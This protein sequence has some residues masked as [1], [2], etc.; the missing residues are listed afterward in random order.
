M[1]RECRKADFLPLLSGDLARWARFFLCVWLLLAGMAGSLAAAET[2]SKPA[3]RP[4]IS[5]FGNVEEFPPVE[6]R[7][8]RFLIFE[9]NRAAPGLDELEI[10]TAEP[11]PRNAAL[12]S[13]GA[14]ATASSSLEIPKMHHLGNVNDGRYGNESSWIAGDEE[15]TNNWWVQIELPRATRIGKIVWS[16]D[17]TGQNATRMPTRYRIE[18]AVAPDDW[19]VVA[20]SEE[21]AP[22]PEPDLFPVPPRDSS[23]SPREYSVQKGGEED[24]FPQSQV[25]A[26]TQTPDGYLWVGTPHSLVRFDGNQFTVF[27]GERSP[28]IGSFGVRWLY[29][30]RLG[31]LFILV[32]A[33]H[34]EAANNLIIY[35]NGRFTRQDSEGISL[36]GVFE[37]DAGQIWGTSSAGVFPWMNGRFDRSLGLKEFDNAGEVLFAVGEDSVVWLS[38]PGLAGKLTHGRFRALRGKDGQEL[39]LDGRYTAVVVPRSDGGAW[40]LEGGIYDESARGPNLWRR[41]S[42][43]GVL[44]ELKPFPWPVNYFAYDTA[45]GDSAGNLWIGSRQLGLVKLSPDGLRPEFYTDKEGLKKADVIAMFRDREG[46]IWAGGFRGGL[47]RLRKPLFQTI[48]ERS[49]LADDNV[50]SLSPSRQGGVW[51]GTHIAGAYR[52]QQDGLMQHTRSKPHSWS[53]M[54][55]SSGAFW[56]GSYGWGLTRFKDG[57]D[58][59]IHTQEGGDQRYPLALLEG[60]AGRIWIGGAHGL[61]SFDNNTGAVRFYAPPLFE[62]SFRN[63]VISLAEDN[64]GALWLGTRGGYLHRFQD[65]AFKTFWEP[66]P[67]FHPVCAIYSHGGGELWFARFGFGLTRLKEG[68]LTHYSVKEGLPTTTINGI[69]NDGR[70]FLWMTSK[71]GVW[72]ISTNDFGSFAAGQAGGFLWTRFT[73]QDGLPS[74]ECHGEQNKPSVCQTPDGRIWIPTVRG[75]GVIDP[76]ALTNPGTA[77]SA[78]VQQVQVISAGNHVL[79]LLNDGEFDPQKPH[80][81]TIPAGA[82]NLLIRYTAADLANPR[83]VR[84]RHRLTGLDP[85]WVD[86]GGSRSAI[87][88]ALAPGSFRFE[89][90]AINERGIL[91]SPAALELRVLP[92]WWQTWAFRGAVG[93]LLILAGPVFYF[94]R[95]KRLQRRNELQQNFSRQLIQRE[96]AERQRVAQQVHDVLGHELLLLKNI[97]AQGAQKTDPGSPARDQFE[98]MSSQASRALDETREISHRLRPVELDRLG[99]NHALEALLDSTSATTGLRVFKD[100]D[101]LGALLPVELQLH[102]YRLVQ[103]GLSN[104]LKHARASTVTLELKREGDQ[105]RLQLGDDGVGFDPALVAERRAGLGLTGLEERVKLMGGQFQISSSPGAGTRLQVTIPLPPPSQS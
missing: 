51:I 103:E 53:V 57:G 98:R 14:V 13:A 34:A 93:A 49:G 50:Y 43:D 25:N 84:F 78:I 41:L 20:T 75:V 22:N 83:K 17:R 19:K 89:L 65:G 104:V 40:I 99:L 27:G 67:E 37:D 46:N 23:K 6:V 7:F 100:L 33:H 24:F 31:R 97:A 68:K 81:L 61:S 82:N 70:G 71:Q 72:R 92:H 85:A 10:F 55:D 12:Q 90:V 101:D 66:T 47:S 105:L 87:Y 64:D 35:E 54:E 4:P 95:I 5:P 62:K 9:T 52:W 80:H 11:E 59:T 73:Q 102:L 29:V 38:K 94:D 21:R 56:N 26:I 28:E 3:L 8:V 91:S 96:E 45:E 16:R 88:A 86:A 32:G 76:A 2:P 48:D 77:A 63:W 58:Q 44:S 60:R 39:K 36:S 15:A 30:D 1:R 69:L 79:S 74:D 18:V 42:A